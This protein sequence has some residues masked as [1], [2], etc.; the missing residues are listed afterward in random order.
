MCACVRV[1][2]SVQAGDRF[3]QVFISPYLRQKQLLLQLCIPTST[4]KRNVECKQLLL[5]RSGLSVS[6][7]FPL[8]PVL[9]NRLSS[10]LF[11]RLPFSPSPRCC[12]ALPAVQ[13]GRPGHWDPAPGSLRWRLCVRGPSCV[14]RSLG[15]SCVQTSSS[16][17]S[18]PAPPLLVPHVLHHQRPKLASPGAPQEWGPAVLPASVH[19]AHAG[20]HAVAGAAGGQEQCGAGGAHGGPEATAGGN[21]PAHRTN[22]SRVTI[23]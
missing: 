9:F 16:P 4:C 2:V 8:L 19:L 20:G 23:W 22:E 21:A 13:R 11:L 7:L 18:F 6:P 17:P 3:L 14:S 15:S 1:C 5:A 12:P 10:A